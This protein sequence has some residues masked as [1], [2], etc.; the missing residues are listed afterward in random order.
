MQEFIVITITSIAL[1]YL[2]YKFVF[3]NKSHHCDKC[4]LTKNSGSAEVN[5]K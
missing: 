2:I 1:S 4:E 3:K 5:A